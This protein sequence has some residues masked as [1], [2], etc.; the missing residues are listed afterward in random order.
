MMLCDGSLVLTLFV[1]AL[2]G[3]N[4]LVGLLPSL[5]FFGWLMPQFFAAGSLQRLNRFLPAVQRLEAV[6]SAFYLLIGLCALAFAQDQ[7]EW[8]LFIF[9]VLFLST[10][11]AAGSSNV[12]RAEIV[13]RMVPPQDRSTVISVRQFTGGIA[14]FL[15]GFV[16]RYILDPRVSQFPNNYATLFGLSGIGFALAVA[17]MSFVKEPDL[18]IKPRRMD[19]LQ[20]LKRAPGLLGEDR[21]FMLYIG[22][23]I[24]STGIELATPFYILYATEVLGAPAYMAGIYISILTFSQVVSNM[25]WALQCKR[26][27]NLFVLRTAY[28]LGISAPVWVI[29]LPR[30]LGIIWAGQIPPIAMWLLGLAFFVKGLA[31]SARGIGETA[32]LYDIAPERERLT[33][34]GLTNTVLGPLYFLPALGGALL[35][36]IGY[37]PIFAA[38]AVMVGGAFLFTSLLIR[39]RQPEDCPAAL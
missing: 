1:R 11:I 32:Y 31:G 17:A 12:A 18:P 23:R 35:D 5:K 6:R 26:R 13:A 28:V 4:L 19:W 15:S 37:V 25:F 38:S 30:I 14:G 24:A 10:R 27:G 39:Q 8:V 16:V 33:Y 3:S 34:Y 2:G 7:P 29:L 20:Q 22:M 36:A 21:R 9:F